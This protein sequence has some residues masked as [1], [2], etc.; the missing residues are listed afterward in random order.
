MGFSGRL[1]SGEEAVVKA[2]ERAH[3]PD[4]TWAKVDS[5][6]GKTDRVRGVHVL[7]DGKTVNFS[8]TR[9]DWMFLRDGVNPTEGN[10]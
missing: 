8:T 6:D 4:G 10:P 9:R 1:V 2:G 7:S 5:V 3:L